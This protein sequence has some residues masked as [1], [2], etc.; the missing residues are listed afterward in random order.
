MARR[1]PETEAA[2]ALPAEADGEDHRERFMVHGGDEGISN[3]VPGTSAPAVN[4]EAV[5]RRL[6]WPEHRRTRRRSKF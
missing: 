3:A 1:V 6:E 4:V 5:L 2:G